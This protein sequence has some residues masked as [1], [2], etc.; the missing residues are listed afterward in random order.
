MIAPITLIVTLL[1][2]NDP[3]VSSE[4]L[5]RRVDE[6][7]LQR[8]ACGPTCLWYCLRWH[9]KDVKLA[10]VVNSS[11]IQAAGTDLADLAR[12]SR[13][14]DLFCRP[15]QF[16]TSHLSDLPVPSILVVNDNH[17]IVYLGRAEAEGQCQIFEPLSGQQGLE[18]LETLQG[19]CTGVALIFQPEKHESAM[20]NIGFAV[21]GIALVVLA[22]WFPWQRTRSSKR[23]LRM[24][25]GM[26]SDPVTSVS[27]MLVVAS[28]LILT[29]VTPVF[30]EAPP[31]KK[32]ENST[33][34]KQEDAALSANQILEIMRANDA[35]FDNVKMKYDYVKYPARQSWRSSQSDTNDIRTD[36]TDIQIESDPDVDLT[37][38]PN[39]ED[40]LNLAAQSDPQF[41]KQLHGVDPPALAEDLKKWVDLIRT[42]KLRIRVHDKPQAPSPPVRS[43]NVVGIRWPDLAVERHPEAGANAGSETVKWR[44]VGQRIENLDI[45]YANSNSKQAEWIRTTKVQPIA[46][47]SYQEL[48]LWLKFAIGIGYADLVDKVT[49]LDRTG[50]Q[51]VM[52]GEMQIWPEQIA[53][54]RF[55]LDEKYLVRKAEIDSNITHLLVTSNGDYV[56]QGHAF[57]CA[58]SGSFERGFKASQ[59]PSTKFDVNVTNIQFDMSDSEFNELADLATPP[60]QKVQDIDLDQPAP[61]VLKSST[62]PADPGS[63]GLLVGLNVLVIGGLA[64]LIRRRMRRAADDQ[65]KQGAD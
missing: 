58:K 19:V 1:L 12:Q 63:R 5:A 54:F 59:D 56:I 47:N 7:T 35:Q 49:Q 23:I 4:E 39:K 45:H 42:K 40:L 9:G 55:E 22:I 16:E 65:S 50:A 46:L 20:T 37:G 29:G 2:G 44:S 38:I 18:S 6:L 11:K 43:H 25:P 21:S 57:H 14:L 53:T 62:L 61:G 64:W 27:T 51:I 28:T 34:S 36:A 26:P 3:L 52:I 10:D 41:Y 8:N 60:G 32:S 17:S 31:A 30:A 33:S 15:I 48:I 13:E 24:G